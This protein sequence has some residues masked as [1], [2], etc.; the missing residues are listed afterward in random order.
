MISNGLFEE[1]NEQCIFCKIC[2][3]NCVL[4][5]TYIMFHG[6]TSMK[7][8]SLREIYNNNKAKMKKNYDFMRAINCIH[9]FTC[10]CTSGNSKFAE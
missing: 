5:F 6:K 9:K 8:F 7:N 2:I 4:N 3:I 10:V 1:T